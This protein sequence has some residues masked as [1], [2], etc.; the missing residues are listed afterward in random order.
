MIRET[1]D[2]LFS[3]S[4]YPKFQMDIPMSH[5]YK[6]SMDN[7]FLNKKGNVYK[8]QHLDSQYLRTV[9]EQP[10]E[11]VLFLEYLLQSVH[12]SSNTQKLIPW[13]FVQ[14]LVLPHFMFGFQS[15]E[16]LERISNKAKSPE[17]DNSFL[18]ESQIIHKRQKQFHEAFSHLPKLPSVYLM[19]MQAYDII[20]LEHITSNICHNETIFDSPG[21]VVEIDSL[22]HSK[23]YI[24]MG[25]YSEDNSYFK[26][27]KVYGIFHGYIK[28]QGHY[29]AVV[30]YY[31]DGSKVSVCDDRKDSSRQKSGNSY[32]SGYIYIDIE[33][34]LPI[35]A[36]MLENVIAIQTDGNKKVS[37]NI[38]RRVKM[39]KG[40]SG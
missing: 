40:M 15:S 23:S 16:D 10:H 39:C 30:E 35:I 20:G 4:I 6:I 26:N 22:S 2:S 33:T 25:F 17:E 34:S 1:L 9:T 5:Q 37:V 12:F 3:Q 38:R 27:A 18:V 14:N 36:T 32:Y 29:C 7:Q 28:C 11:S 13:K 24:G 19:I 31:S 21:E 8:S